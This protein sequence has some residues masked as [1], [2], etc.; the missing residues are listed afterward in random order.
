MQGQGQKGKGKYCTWTEHGTYDKGFPWFVR[1][2]PYAHTVSPGEKDLSEGLLLVLPSGWSA[3]MWRW[4]DEPSHHEDK[5][6]I[7]KRKCRDRKESP[8]LTRA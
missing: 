4:Q 2:W 3:L 1:P 8:N 5:Q 6:E 7:K